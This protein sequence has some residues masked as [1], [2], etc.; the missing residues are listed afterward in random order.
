MCR[1]MAWTLDDLRAC[2]TE[3]VE[4]LYQLILAEAPPHGR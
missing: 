2:S 1:Y 3:E 4:A